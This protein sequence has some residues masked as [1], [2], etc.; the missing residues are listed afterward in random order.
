MEPQ[1]IKGIWDEVVPLHAASLKGHHVE[2]RVLDGGNVGENV[3]AEGFEASM[4]RIAELTKGAAQISP[5][6]LRAEDF[7][8]SAE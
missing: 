6:P 3:D 4:L 8:E 1:I 5:E 7:Y 2:I